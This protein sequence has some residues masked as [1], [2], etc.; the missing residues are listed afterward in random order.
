MYFHDHHFKTSNLADINNIRNI[1]HFHFY[2][3]PTNISEL[4]SLIADSIDALNVEF[5]PN[6]YAIYIRI[7][8]TGMRKF[9]GFRQDPNFYYQI[10]PQI[11]SSFINNHKNEIISLLT[12]AGVINARESIE[13]LLI[14]RQI[15]ANLCHI[16]CIADNI[17]IFKL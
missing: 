12:N 7:K 16:T 17:V 15:M 9:H 11:F 3:N 4:Q 10:T 8:K 2:S 5:V 14:N 1:L 6:E 13:N